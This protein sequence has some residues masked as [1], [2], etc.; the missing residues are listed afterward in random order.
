MKTEDEFVAFWLNE[1]TGLVLESFHEAKETSKHQLD[2]T[3]Q[4]K[5]FIQQLSRVKD[6]LKRMY[7][8]DVADPTPVP[9]KG[10]SEQAQPN[11]KAPL[12]TRPQQAPA[13]PAAITNGSAGRQAE[14]R[15]T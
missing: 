3:R 9:T 13:R 14:A 6:M 11:A 8:Q 15:R 10:T 1:T 7:R 5:C 12:E 2:F 4:G